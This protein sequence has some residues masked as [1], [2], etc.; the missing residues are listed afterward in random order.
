MVSFRPFQAAD[1]VALDLQPSQHFECGLDEPCVSLERGRQLEET[2]PAWTAHDGD[3]IL[4]CAGFAERYAG[5]N[6]VAWAMFSAELGT[7]GLA[8]TRFARARVLEASYRRIDAIVE[9]DN[10][11]AACWA[12]SIGFTLGHVL[13][14]WGAAAEPHLLFERI[15]L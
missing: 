5:V 2:G 8:I 4:C 14:C 11:R 10:A 7:A 6:A 9:R 1:V 13:H 15:R 3:K 12:R